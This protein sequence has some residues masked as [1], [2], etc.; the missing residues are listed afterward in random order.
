MTSTDLRFERSAAIYAPP[1]HVDLIGLVIIIIF[2][3]LV[4]GL[5]ILADRKREEKKDKLEGRALTH[6][7]ARATRTVH[8]VGAICRIS[9]SLYG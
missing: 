2:F 8:S 4:S 5:Q 6:S 9:V 1:S 3:A 7:W